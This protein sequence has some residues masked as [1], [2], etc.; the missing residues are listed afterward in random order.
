LTKKKKTELRK[1]IPL[2]GVAVGDQELAEVPRDVSAFF[3]QFLEERVCGGTVDVDL[4]E[5]RKLGA[6]AHGK[7]LNFRVGARLLGAKLV[8]GEP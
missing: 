6:F 7:G 2:D 5:E 1:E 3:L 8:A 4:G